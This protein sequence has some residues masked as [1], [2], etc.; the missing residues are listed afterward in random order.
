MFVY[1]YSSDTSDLIRNQNENISVSPI[2]QFQSTITETDAINNNKNAELNVSQKLSPYSNQHQHK[3]DVQYVTS[4]TRQRPNSN[5]DQTV[6]NS[7]DLRLNDWLTKHNIDS[8]SKNIILTELFSYDDFI[9][10]I[11]KADLYR[12]GL[13]YVNVLFINYL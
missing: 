11:D 2:P 5:H 13:K 8:I 9:Y 1:S 6:S 7:I 4:T 10:E 3:F 12:V